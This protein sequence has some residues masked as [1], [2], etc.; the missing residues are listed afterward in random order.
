MGCGAR[1]PLSC[2]T[3]PGHDGGKGDFY[4]FAQVAKAWRA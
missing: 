1:K 2:A 4:G 3:Q